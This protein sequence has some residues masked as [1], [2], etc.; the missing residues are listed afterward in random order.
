MIANG[1][2]VFINRKRYDNTAKSSKS[3]YSVTFPKAFQQDRLSS[4]PGQFWPSSLICDTP[5]ISHSCQVQVT[6]LSLEFAQAHRWKNT[7]WSDRS[8]FLLWHS[9]VRIRIWC[10]QHEMMESAVQVMLWGDIFLSYFGPLGTNW[11]SFKCPGLPENHCWPSCC[12]HSVSSTAGGFQQ[13]NTL[14]HK[15]QISSSLCPEDDNEFTALPGPPQSPDLNPLE[16]L[17][18]VVNNMFTSQMCSCSSCVMLSCQNGPT[19]L[20]NLS[21]LNLPMLR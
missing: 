4:L 7:V 2:S 15:A 11:A 13:V 5:G 8:Q 17:L 6:W 21:V 18:D 3:M 10:K 12:N 14:C 9:D 19:S 1:S 20:R 16:H